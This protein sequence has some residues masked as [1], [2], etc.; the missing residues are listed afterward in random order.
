MKSLEEL[1]FEEIARLRS[2]L[3][4]ERVQNDAMREALAAKDYD[5]REWQQLAVELG[6]FAAVTKDKTRMTLD[7]TLKI[8]AG[9]LAKST[10]VHATV[11]GIVF[12]QIVRPMVRECEKSFGP[13][14]SQRAVNKDF[15]APQPPKP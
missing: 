11:S 14:S 8:D 2:R 7:C 10:N 6:A 12:N 15:T 1:H 3:E 13:H 5:L 4:V 9:L